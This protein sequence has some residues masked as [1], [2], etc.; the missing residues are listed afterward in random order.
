MR[1]FGITRMTVLRVVALSSLSLVLPLAS[2]AARNKEGSPGPPIASTGGFSHASGSS[3]VLKGG[4]DPRTLPTTYYF[5]YGPTAAY[6]SQTTP[7]SLPA[8]TVKVKVSQTVKAILVGYHYR[9]V[10]T[11]ADGTTNRP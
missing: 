11:N 10:A 5:Q 7:A 1:S 9:L 6:G 3:A 8:G 4:V 2:E